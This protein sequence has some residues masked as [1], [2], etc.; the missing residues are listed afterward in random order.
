MKITAYKCPDTGKIFEHRSEYD[1][2]RF[3][4]LCYRAEKARIK[5]IKDKFE[6][7]ITKLRMTAKSTDDI[8]EWVLK[9]SR[10]LAAFNDAEPNDKFEIS[11][12][13]FKTKWR[14]D[15]SNSHSAPFSG[16]T[17]W[18]GRKPGITRSYPGFNGSIDFK[19]HGDLRN[20]FQL[21]K[22]TG[23]NT[24][25][26]GGGGSGFHAEV[27]LFADDWPAMAEKQLEHDVWI[28]LRDGKHNMNA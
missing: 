18:G 14:M 23:I 24:G 28:L 16:E 7:K 9:Y 13:Q 25:T 10:E 12:I 27:T 15:C 3:D 8:E 2:Y 26:G 19:Y 11:S 17:N 1:E 5:A 21:L 20:F 22:K 4:V 6:R